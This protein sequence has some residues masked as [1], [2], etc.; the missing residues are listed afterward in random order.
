MRLTIRVHSH[1]GKQVDVISKIIPVKY[2][3]DNSVCTR[4]HKFQTDLKLQWN[5]LFLL[6]IDINK[7]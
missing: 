3:G 7:F 6:W 1:D 2:S 4:A 5:Y